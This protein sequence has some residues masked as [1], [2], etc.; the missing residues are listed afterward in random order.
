MNTRKKRLIGAAMTM[1]VLGAVGLV[2]AAWTTN[3]SGTGAAQ[4]GY[5][6]GL[7]TVDATASTT[8]LLYPNGDGTV[9][10][11]IHNP[12]SYPVVVT[13]VTP[14]PG[15]VTATGGIGVCNLTGVRFR[16]QHDLDIHVPP[17]SDSNVIELQDAAHMTNESEDGCQG[18]TFSIPV[19]LTGASGDSV[20][21]T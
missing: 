8:G 21:P 4:A 19:V 2:Y 10:L 3:G 5:A 15:E 20:S 18:A 16:A 12:N 7:S 14:G 11:Q 1:L 13:D 9:T 6:Q 17:N